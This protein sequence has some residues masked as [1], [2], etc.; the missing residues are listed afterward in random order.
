[1]TDESTTNAGDSPTVR[2][3]RLLAATAG[4]VAVG[5]AGCLEST[6]EGPYG[7]Y[8]AT[9]NNFEEVA[10]RTGNDEVRVKV[11][12]GEEALAFG[13]AA[14]EVSPGTKIVWEW[15]GKGGRHNVV[16]ENGAFES[17]LYVEVGQTFSQTFEEPGVVKYLCSPHE[18]Q[19]MLGVI[20]VV[21]G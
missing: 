11:G 7:G 16:E 17:P 5:T 14:V 15:T 6:D 8:L 4:A 12:A 19:G 2:R 3:R 20:D 13:P 21:E 18:T 10:D 1:M 9:A